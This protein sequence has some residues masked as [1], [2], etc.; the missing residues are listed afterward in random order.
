MRVDPLGE[1]RANP[2]PKRPQG[3][4]KRLQLVHWDEPTSEDEQLVEVSRGVLRELESSRRSLY[5]ILGAR[6]LGDRA[7]LAQVAAAELAQ[8]AALAEVDA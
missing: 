8:S 2:D 5:N 7:V 1:Q 3:T 4:R 6:P